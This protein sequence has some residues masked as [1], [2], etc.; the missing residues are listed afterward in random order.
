MAVKEQ[1]RSNYPECPN[2]IDGTGYPDKEKVD[3]FS[4]AAAL[5]YNTQ[6]SVA[7]QAPQPPLGYTPAE[8]AP[9]QP[10]AAPV[11]GA[12][13]HVVAGLLAIFLGALGI[14]KFYLG[15]N[16]A[17]FITL[18]VTVLGSIFTF[19]LAALVIEL[20]SLIEGII[21]L[22]KSQTDFDQIYVL[23]QRDWF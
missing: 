13:D 8:D 3:T 17:A 9:R 18:A 23:H 20:I 7:R 10:A 16:K 12:K 15:Y 21:Y 11:F 22:T 1:R 5:G 2:R 14:H 19:G 6:A 4:Y